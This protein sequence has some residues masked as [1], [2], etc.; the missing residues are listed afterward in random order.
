MGVPLE[1]LSTK[2]ITPPGV[3]TGIN[4][5]HIT[6]FL[7]FGKKR[8][9]VFQGFPTPFPLDLVGYLDFPLEDSVNARA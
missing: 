1:A 8:G 5:I 9:S 6:P 4:Y 3:F 2:P 7:D